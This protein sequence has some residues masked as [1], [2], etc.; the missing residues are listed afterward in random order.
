VRSADA[1]R[2]VPD[3]HRPVSIATAT[4]PQ[5]IRKRAG[6]APVPPNMPDYASESAAFTWR[7]ARSALDGLPGGRGLN[8]AQEAVDRHAAG[9]R[10]RAVALRW[11]A[12]DGGAVDIAY[13]ELD[14]PVARVCSAEVPMPY[15]HQLEEAALP[16]AARVVTAARELMGAHG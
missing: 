6:A 7:A 12:R 16:S 8:I 11:L 10:R 13:E 15:A 4:R 1:R 5:P 2:P 9:A 3:E 14:A